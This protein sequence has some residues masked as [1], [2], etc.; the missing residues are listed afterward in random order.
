MSR[1]N[2][3]SLRWK[4]V[5][6]VRWCYFKIVYGCEEGDRSHDKRYYKGCIHVRDEVVRYRE[7]GEYHYNPNPLVDEKGG[8]IPA[9]RL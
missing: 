2:Y 8:E 9:V 3:L 7:K 4:I 1:L 6:V 5:Y